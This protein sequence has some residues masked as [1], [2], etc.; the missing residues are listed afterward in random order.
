MI[1]NHWFDLTEYKDH[2]GSYTLFKEYH[3]KDATEEFNKNKGHYDG[4]VLGLM[5][6]FLIKDVELINA[7]QNVCN[8][9]A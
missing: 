7:I 4:Y 1:D 8:T 6:K 9:S 3:L 5:D 2:P